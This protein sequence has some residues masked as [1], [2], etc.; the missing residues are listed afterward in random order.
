MREVKRLETIKQLTRVLVSKIL[1]RI[2]SMRASEKTHSRLS[3]RSQFLPLLSQIQHQPLSPL[4]RSLIL[5]TSR[6]FP[7][8]KQLPSSSCTQTPI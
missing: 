2:K 4:Q 1:L 3:L 6:I 5:Q 7:L 8:T